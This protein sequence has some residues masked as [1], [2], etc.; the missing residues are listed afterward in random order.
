MLHPINETR[1]FR[2]IGM[3][4]SSTA[5]VFIK[6]KVDDHQENIEQFIKVEIKEEFLNE[7]IEIEENMFLEKNMTGWN[8]LPQDEYTEES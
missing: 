6:E 3:A 4:S 7:N 1:F 8:F 2:I 5:K